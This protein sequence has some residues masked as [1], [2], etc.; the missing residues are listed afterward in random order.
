MFAP[1][2][3]ALAVSV[4]VLLFMKDSPEA[5]GFPPIDEGA[6]KNNTHDK[7]AGG[8]LSNDDVNI[9]DSRSLQRFCTVV[10]TVHPGKSRKGCFNVTD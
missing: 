3:V 5:E 4:L 10:V 8:H 2:S 1:G 9:F 7:P 6:P